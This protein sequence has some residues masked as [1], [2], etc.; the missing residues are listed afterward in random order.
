MKMKELVE[1]AN[2][3]LAQEMAD[4]RMGELKERLMQIRCAKAAIKRL[5]DDLADFLETDTDDCPCCVR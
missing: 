3:E 1:L 4:E 5:E 2:D